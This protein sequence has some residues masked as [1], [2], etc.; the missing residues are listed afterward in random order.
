MCTSMVDTQ[1]VTAEIGKEKKKK[2]KKE[3]RNHRTKIYCMHLLHRTAI[4][5]L[6]YRQ[7]KQN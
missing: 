5:I 4:I 3:E 7:Q 6:F 2:R 1:S